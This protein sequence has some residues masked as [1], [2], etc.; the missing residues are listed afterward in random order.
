[1]SRTISATGSSAASFAPV[2]IPRLD[3]ASVN[4]RARRRTGS[5]RESQ[6]PN[7]PP[8]QGVRFEVIGVVRD[9][10]NAPPGQ[11]VEPAVYFTT[12]QLP[13]RELFVTV[14]AADRNAALVRSE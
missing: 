8:P 12:R 1:M 13:F 6:A 4:L 9:V 10:R 14:R 7:P 5:G 3:E 2:S 11:G